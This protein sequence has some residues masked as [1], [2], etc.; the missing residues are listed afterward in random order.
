MQEL[1]E[2]L[3]VRN[4]VTFMIAVAGFLIS[5]YT[6]ISG[7]YKSLECYELRVVD[8]TTH[9]DVAQLLL[10][11]ENHSDSPLTIVEFSAFGKTCELRPKRIR[12]KPESFGFQATPQFP[13][14]ISAHGAQYAYLE[15]VG[16]DVPVAGLYPGSTVRLRVRSTRREESID[17]ALSRISCYL[18]TRE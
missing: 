15:F 10:C 13:I 3:S 9:G 17:I 12:G 2:W 4:N 18:H 1:L 6:M 7:W 8:Y 11:I 5:S 16:A 14:C